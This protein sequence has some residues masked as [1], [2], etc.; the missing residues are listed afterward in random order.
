MASRSPVVPMRCPAV[1]RGC[2]AA[3]SAEVPGHGEA[4]QRLWASLARASGHRADDADAIASHRLANSLPKVRVDWAAAVGGRRLASPNEARE[5]LPRARARSAS[6]RARAGRVRVSRPA[7]RRRALPSWTRVG[8]QLGG[9]HEARPAPA[10]LAQY[11]AA[12][13]RMEAESAA[14]RDSPAV[15]G[16]AAGRGASRPSESLRERAAGPGRSAASGHAVDGGG[17]CPAPDLS[18]PLP[19][20]GWRRRRLAG[21]LAAGRRRLACGSV[22]SAPRPTIAP[23]GSSRS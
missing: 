14:S 16:A 5:Q 10:P 21:V 13:V 6:A 18:L 7:A 2:G 3:R 8:Q 4:A 23:W 9:Q 22:R 11:S 20:A 12:T 15:A 19:A 17:A 1:Q